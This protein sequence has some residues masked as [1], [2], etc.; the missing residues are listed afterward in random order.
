MKLDR[1]LQYKEL[2]RTMGSVVFS[3]TT[4]VYISECSTT[5]KGVIKKL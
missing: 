3:G 1:Y 4:C 5:Y 2:H